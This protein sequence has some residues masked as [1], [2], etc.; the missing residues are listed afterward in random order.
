MINYIIVKEWS[1]FLSIDNISGSFPDQGK[2]EEGGY[3][4]YQGGEL[5]VNGQYFKSGIV[6]TGKRVHYIFA[7]HRSVLVS[8]LLVRAVQ[9]EETVIAQPP[10]AL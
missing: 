7:Y 3:G 4:P 1:F 2:I 9:V 10:Q 5:G 8:A 6:L